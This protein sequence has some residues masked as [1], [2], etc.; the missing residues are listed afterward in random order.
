MFDKIISNYICIIKIAENQR[1]FFYG[2]CEEEVRHLL[3][4]E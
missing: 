2:A 1:L 4:H 3:R